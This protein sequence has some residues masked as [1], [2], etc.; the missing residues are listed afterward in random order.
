MKLFGHPD[1]GH[2][3]K[4]KFFL[5]WLGIDYNYEFVDIFSKRETRSQEFLKAS[6]FAEVPALIDEG[7]C[8]TQSN[9]ILFYLADKFDVFT[10]AKQRQ[11]CLQWL[12]WEANKIGLCLPQIRAHKKL[13]PQYPDFTLSQGAYEWLWNRYQHDV[14][15]LDNELNNKSFILGDQVSPADFALSAYLLYTD[16][17]AIDVPENVSLWLGRMPALPGWQS[18]YDMLKGHIG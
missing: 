12:V 9:A 17:I 15:V 8:Y 7:H 10:N 16:E 18:P 3:L 6:K 11:A 4:V 1:S 5:D 2:A 13:S 14:G